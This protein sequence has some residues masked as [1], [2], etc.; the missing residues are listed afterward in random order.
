M[1]FVKKPKLIQ[2]MTSNG[3]AYE[4]YI[5]YNQYS[6]LLTHQSFLIGFRFVFVLVQSSVCLEFIPS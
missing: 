1:L 4:C 3:M 6:E 2:S 5:R